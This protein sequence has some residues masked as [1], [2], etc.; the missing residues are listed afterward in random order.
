MWVV[1][2]LPEAEQERAA[3][4]KTER[5]ALAHADA[6][7]GAYGPL[8]GYP[9]TSAVRGTEKLRNFGPGLDVAPTGRCTGKSGRCSWLRP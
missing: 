4:P 7:L 8:L 5:A 6:K 2:Y 3:L 1:A 9:H